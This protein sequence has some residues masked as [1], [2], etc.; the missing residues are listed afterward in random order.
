[1]TGTICLINA[2]NIVWHNLGL[3]A[4]AIISAFLFRNCGRYFV[5]R[6]KNLRGQL[7]LIGSSSTNSLMSGVCLSCGARRSP[8]AESCGRQTAKRKTRTGRVGTGTKPVIESLPS[9]WKTLFSGRAVQRIFFY[10][11]AKS[12]INPVSENYPLCR[13]YV[14]IP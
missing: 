2:L 10:L 6:M 13:S 9:S 5:R 1:M 14:V 12:G 4:L 8:V 7:R 3:I 11:A